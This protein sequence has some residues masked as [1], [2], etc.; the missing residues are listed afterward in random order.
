MNF[1]DADKLHALCNVL[2][3]VE[4]DLHVWSD[5]S[6]TV[7]ANDTVEY[8]VVEDSSENDFDAY[9]HLVGTSNMFLVYSNTKFAESPIKKKYW[10]RIGFT[11]EM[12]EDDLE[13][14][15]KFPA[16]KM[17]ELIRDGKAYPDGT[18]YFPD[19]GENVVAGLDVFE[20]DM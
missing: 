8:Y 18:S 11:V 10:A 9:P 17:R 12:T 16:K 2:N 19:E 6:V 15:K 7:G 14:F 20:F 3:V 13:M 1:Y 4:K 5:D